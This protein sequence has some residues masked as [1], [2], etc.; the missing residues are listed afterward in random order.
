MSYGWIFKEAG[1]GDRARESQVEKFFNADDVANRANAIV[2]EGIQNSLD[3]APDD[4]LVRVRIAIGV[5]SE[6]KQS[7]RLA[8]YTAGLLEHFNAE[9]VRTKIANQPAAGDTFRYLVFED[10]G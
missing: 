10:F 5:W 8:V 2:R 7:E 1:P 4:V 9:A 3:A 6:Q